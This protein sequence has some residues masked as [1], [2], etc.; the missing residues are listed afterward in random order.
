MRKAL[1]LL[2]LTVGLLMLSRE[3]TARFLEDWPFKEADLVVVAVAL[4]SEAVEAKPPAGN[5]WP[6]ELVGRITTFRV[7]HAIKGEAAGKRVT[8]LHFE[9]G[10]LKQGRDDG[11]VIINGPLLVDFPV[12]RE[13]PPDERDNGVL[14]SAPQYLL[15]LRQDGDRYEPVSGQID[16]ALSVRRLCEPQEPSP[17]WKGAKE[18]AGRQPAAPVPASRRHAP[19]QAAPAGAA[20]AKQKS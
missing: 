13:A 17:P 18:A 4:K 8:I 9:F 10:Q 19:G 3:A 16:P 6:Y 7:V 2:A 12:A 11:D 5:E 14:S 1:P 20:D 15:F